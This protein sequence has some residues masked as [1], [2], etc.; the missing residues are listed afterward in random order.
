[1]YKRTT[2]ETRQRRKA[3]LFEYYHPQNKYVLRRQ[4]RRAWIRAEGRRIAHQVLLKMAA[5]GNEGARNLLSAIFLFGSNP[6]LY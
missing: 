5:N 4:K 6:Y 2:K 3:E 1:M